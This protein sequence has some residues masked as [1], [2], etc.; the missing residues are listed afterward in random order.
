MGERDKKPRQPLL[1]G[2]AQF[3]MKRM[4]TQAEIARKERKVNRAGPLDGAPKFPSRD[5]AGEIM[6]PQYQ[7]DLQG[8]EIVVFH[9]EDVNGVPR[10]HTLPLKDY[11]EMIRNKNQPKFKKK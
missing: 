1:F 7:I 2:I 4:P 8:H 3:L 10:T 9:I 5:E 11:E 6:D